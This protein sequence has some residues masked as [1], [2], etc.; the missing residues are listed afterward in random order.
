MQSV[1]DLEAEAADLSKELGS[2]IHD[3]TLARSSEPW[4]PIS[5][6][7]L[8]GVTLP[9]T[10]QPNLVDLRIPIPDLYGFASSA[11]VAITATRLEL[12]MHGRIRPVPFCAEVTAAVIDQQRWFYVDVREN[13]D[14]LLH[15][16]T[17]C[18]TPSELPRIF[19]HLPLKGFVE[20]LLAYLDDPVGAVES[21]IAN[22]VNGINT[23][24]ADVD[25]VLRLAHLLEG[26]AQHGDSLI[27]ID[28]GLALFPGNPWLAQKRDQIRKFF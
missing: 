28:K 13:S 23:A 1:R 5:A 21:E 3:M 10:V 25:H 20:A 14:L 12:N 4:N 16:H 7:E 2:Q 6:V 9:A 15:R 19:S 11:A 27:V 18:V 17:L 26:L 22:L 8:T 24:G